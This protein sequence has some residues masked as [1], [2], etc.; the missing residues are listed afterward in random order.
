M[1]FLADMGISPLS[2]ECL[3]ASGFESVH[4]HEL[5]LDRLSDSSILSKALEDKQII[6]ASDLDFGELISI[7]GH[8][9]PSVVIFR[10]KDMR[11][12]NVNRYL[13]MIL[14][15]HAQDLETGAISVFR[16][17]AFASDGYRSDPELH[18]RS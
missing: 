1:K 16:R 5:G 11:P 14:E 13:R 12:I 15:N 3:R 17:D 6:L 8:S 2:V 4:L 9:L 18:R 10:L 7:A